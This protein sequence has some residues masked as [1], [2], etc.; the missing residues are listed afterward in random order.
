MLTVQ[1]VLPWITGR[2][3]LIHLAESEVLQFPRVQQSNNEMGNHQHEVSGSSRRDLIVAI[4]MAQ[5]ARIKNNI[6][7]ELKTTSAAFSR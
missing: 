2:T 7:S 1:H 3:G 6:T 5:C 4:A